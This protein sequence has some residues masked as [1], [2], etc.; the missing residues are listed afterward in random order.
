MLCFLSGLL[1]AESSL[2]ERS[3][4]FFSELRSF[5]QVNKEECVHSQSS[6]WEKL[7]LYH[8]MCN[9]YMVLFCHVFFSLSRTCCSVLCHIKIASSPTWTNAPTQPSF[10]SFFSTQ[11]PLVDR[12]LL[13]VVVCW[14]I[15]FSVSVFIWRTQQTLVKYSNRLWIFNEGV[16]LSKLWNPK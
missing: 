14:A 13:I 16:C 15:L 11:S 12:R 2:T 3:E 10:F 4:Q 1:D 5:R 6:G 9:Y 7:L 8:T